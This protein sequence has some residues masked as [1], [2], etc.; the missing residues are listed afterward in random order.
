M[1]TPYENADIRHVEQEMV[2]LST[3]KSPSDQEQVKTFLR[4]R[5]A[6]LD[7]W[8]RANE[9]ELLP[10]IKEFNVT[11]ERA[12][13]DLY[14]VAHRYYAY[15]ATFDSGIQLVASLRF[16]DT[17]P[18]QH[19]YQ[20][21]DRSSI[22]KCLLEHGWN[23]LFQPGLTELP[24]YFP[25]DAKKSFP[26]FAGSYEETG[27]LRWRGGGFFENAQDE[28]ME[29]Y[30]FG[31]AFYHLAEHTCFALTDFIYVRDFESSIDIHSG[32]QKSYSR[33]FKHNHE[34]I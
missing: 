3:S 33:L 20:S 2:R 23:P 15:M 29:G 30:R 11:V 32:E 6:M 28:E 31:S 13:K 25:Y 8:A 12:L 17:Y 27:L 10:V 16:T 4:L 21:A 9:K 19:P 24:L 5:K 26:L 22:W 7:D 34:T 1:E 14:D 18:R